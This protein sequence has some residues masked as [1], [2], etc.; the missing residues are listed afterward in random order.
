VLARSF[1]VDA[2]QPEQLSDFA[3]LFASAIT[4]WSQSNGVVFGSTPQPQ[5]GQ[6]IFDITLYAQL[7]SLNTPVLRLRNLQLK[8]ADIDPV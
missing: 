2:S 7:S 1:V 3:Q 4:E 6:L 5:G 8:L